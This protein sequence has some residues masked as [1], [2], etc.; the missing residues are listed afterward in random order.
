MA[1]GRESS[2]E[3]GFSTGDRAATLSL[4]SSGYSTPSR[5]SGTGRKLPSIPAGQIPLNL[6]SVPSH[7]VGGSIARPRVDVE[8]MKRVHRHSP[9]PLLDG[10]S[11]E[12]LEAYKE[13]HLM[14]QKRAAIESADAPSC[15]R[16]P[17]D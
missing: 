7:A 4:S 11:W 12:E 16:N 6:P 10:M 2:S 8:A 14:F 1:S 15:A 17:A 9:P 5:R 3:D 13:I